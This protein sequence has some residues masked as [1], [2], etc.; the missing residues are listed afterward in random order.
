[1]DAVIPSPISEY[2]TLLIGGHQPEELPEFKPD[3]PPS[4]QGYMA[5]LPQQ[6]A[7]FDQPYRR[8]IAEAFPIKPVFHVQHYLERI[9]LPALALAGAI[10]DFDM[11]GL[12]AKVRM[13]Y[14]HNRVRATVRKIKLPDVELGLHSGAWTHPNNREASR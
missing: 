10:E 8:A 11:L 3:L 13:G 9:R 1:M 12:R 7:G 2:S 6:F 4:F 5:A 14:Q